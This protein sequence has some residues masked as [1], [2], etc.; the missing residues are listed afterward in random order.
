MNISR[1]T[2]TAYYTTDAPKSTAGIYPFVCEQR[3]VSQHLTR[4]GYSAFIE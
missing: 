3:P 4:L 1:A 2:T